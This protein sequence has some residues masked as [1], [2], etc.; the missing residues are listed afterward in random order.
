MTTKRKTKA[1]KEAEEKAALRQ[2]LTDIYSGALGYKW[3]DCCYEISGKMLMDVIRVCRDV[4]GYDDNVWLFEV[5]NLDKYDTVEQLAEFY[6]K[7]GVRA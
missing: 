4:F 1:Q 3:D 7:N 2:R 6:Y 5:H